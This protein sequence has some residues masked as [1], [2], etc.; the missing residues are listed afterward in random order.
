MG[1]PNPSVG[2][3]GKHPAFGDFVTGGLPA[4]TQST[5]ESWLNRMLPALRDIDETTWQDRFDGAPE[6][7][8]WF[9]AGLVPGGFCGVMRPAKDKV[10]RRFPMVAGVTHCGQMS[11]MLDSSVLLYD[12]IGVALDSFKRGSGDGAPEFA[13][14][15]LNMTAPVI[16][17]REDSTPDFWAARPDG[18]LGRL[19]G[20]IA[21]ADH[22]RAGV[23]RSYMWVNGPGG[24]AIHAADQLQSA[25]VMNWLICDA[26]RTPPQQTEPDQGLINSDPADAP[27]PTH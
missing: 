18:D 8:F 12:E 20:D 10:G 3:Y 27:Q 23:H 9:G 19:A 11:P 26:V 2:L 14:H 16:A 4:D 1:G 7:R 25:D 17:L 15:L 13:A 24:V 22:D 21:V 6:V 5:L